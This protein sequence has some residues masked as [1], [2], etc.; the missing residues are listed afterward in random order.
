M[1]ISRREG[2]AVVLA[3]TK[4]ANI[5][6]K[7]PEGTPEVW[8]DEDGGYSLCIDLNMG[9]YVVAFPVYLDGSDC[10][11]ERK[12]SEVTLAGTSLIDKQD[13]KPEVEDIRILGDTL[14]IELEGKAHLTIPIEEEFRPWRTYYCDSC[15][16]NRCLTIAR[17][18]VTDDT[19]CRLGRAHQAEWKFAHE[20]KST[21]LDLGGSA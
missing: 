10:Y 19:E 15:G 11:S 14:H 1:T 2:E 5:D 13:Y 8:E 20:G 7:R 21:R 4:K 17:C 3:F 12:F 6:Y 9:M 16:E 18:D